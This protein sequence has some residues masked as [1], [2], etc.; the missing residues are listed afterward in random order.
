MS[1]AAV[2][3]A[4]RGSARSISTL[5]GGARHALSVHRTVTSPSSSSS[6]RVSVVSS[7]SFAGSSSGQPR[8]FVSSCIHC[9]Q[10][11]GSDAAKESA[12]TATTTEAEESEVKPKRKNTKRRTKAQIEADRLERVNL[13]L[14]RIRKR[15]SKT[16][17]VNAPTDAGTEGASGSASGSS[18]LTPAEDLS[19]P[20]AADKRR[21][22]KMTNEELEKEAEEQRAEIA[23][24]QEVLGH[25][26]YE[27][28]PPRSEWKKAFPVGKAYS[29][30][31][32]YF[33][34]N[35]ATI[36][37]M[38]EALDLGSTERNGEKV[39]VLEGY[40]GPGT[41]ASQ[42]LQSPHVEKVVALEATPR[43]LKGLEA[44][45]QTLAKKGE[46]DRLDMMPLSAY[47]W[48]SYSALIKSGKLQHLNG[49]V[50]FSDAHTEGEEGSTVDFTQD[51]IAPPDHTDASWQKLSPL[52]F[53]AQLPNTVYGE[54]LFAQT[55]TS[56]AN[57]GWLFRYGRVQL[58]FVCGEALAKRC[59]AQPGD[60]SSRGKLGTTVQ[61]LADVAVHKY[62]EDLQP[63]GHHFFPSTISIGPRVP[64]SGSS[65]IPNSNPSTGLTRTGLVM[66]TV[67]PKQTPLIKAREI[68]AF[69][70]ITRNLFILRAKTVGE[71]LTHVA[72]GG[73]N[74]LNMMTKKQVKEGIIA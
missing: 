56:I 6:S 71:A 39:T 67:T 15:R 49:R 74:I 9:E 64:L 12:S 24:I 70:F 21:A 61:C 45:Q 68:E 34:S 55:V 37:D 43:Y 66:M 33:T 36:A 10:T 50:A 1:S 22:S 58:A 5:L 19:E 20:T 62:P 25:M 2:T 54:Q 11:A 32:R 29:T 46:A 65:L 63:H 38:L 30:S 28:L 18:T 26:E 13:G 14:P 17:L 52:L 42:L 73:Q 48:D 31:F 44:L 59:L 7:T 60:K 69:E 57:R 3:L 53:F 23:S 47:L 4:G 8:G 16:A 51:N 72:P 40:P 35:K 27:H 41:T